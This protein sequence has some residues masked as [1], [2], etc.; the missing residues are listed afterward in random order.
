MGTDDLSNRKKHTRA[1]SDVAII[2][3]AYY[4]DPRKE[5][6][7][8]RFECAL[9][10]LY[11]A[12]HLGYTIFVSDGGS[13]SDVRSELRKYATEVFEDTGKSIVERRQSLA[14][15]AN[16]RSNEVIVWQEI[17][18]VNLPHHLDGIVDFISDEAHNGRSQLVVIGRSAEVLGSYP[19]FQIE[20]EKENNRGFLHAT[21]KDFDVVCGARAWHKPLTSKYF[22]QTMPAYAGSWGD[23]YI[24][25]I[26]AIKSGEHVTGI[27]VPLI[28]PRLQK[29]MEEKY[30]GQFIEKRR[31]QTEE[32]V[33]LYHKRMSE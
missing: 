32:L 3:M 14:G 31:K 8:V 10:T 19:A 13:P 20:F 27:N 16:S 15:I 18:K 6:E 5:M 26:D 22:L 33:A 28:Y 25:I 9:E 2:T 29:E 4:P 12:K 7:K 21:G 1:A 24:P 30:A 17:E 23:T 11:N